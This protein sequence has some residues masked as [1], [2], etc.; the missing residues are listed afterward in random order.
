MQNLSSLSFM[1]VNYR[2]ILNCECWHIQGSPENKN[3]L[4]I[5]AVHMTHALP[6]KVNHLLYV[7]KNMCIVWYM[8]MI[9][10]LLIVVIKDKHKK[11]KSLYMWSAVI[12]FLHTKNVH[13]VEIN[14]QIAD[15]KWWSCNEWRECEDMSNCCWS[16]NE[17]R[18]NVDD[19]QSGQLNSWSVKP[20]EHF[21]Y[22]P[23]VA[24]S[25]YHLFLNLKKFLTA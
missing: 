15:G 25:H 6:M 10:S 16:F 7:K 24:P 14:R 1:R 21:P 18:V 22:S 19:K 2:L 9:F 5:A 11:W 4:W 17:G 13:L 3:W 23:N 20:F 8:V 12:Q